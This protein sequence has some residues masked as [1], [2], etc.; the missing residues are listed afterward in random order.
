MTRDGLIRLWKAEAEET[1]GYSAEEAVGQPI[2]LI[3]PPSFLAEQPELLRRAGQGQRVRSS[4]SIRHHTDGRRL[5]ASIMAS[6]VLD[7]VIGVSAV[8]QDISA[9]QAA[10]AQDQQLNEHLKWQLRQLT[11]LRMLTRPARRA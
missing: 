8:A 7:Q 9:R 2:S 11:G 6:P 5:S 10:K 4:D 3:V 1:Y